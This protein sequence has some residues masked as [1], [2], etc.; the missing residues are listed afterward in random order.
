MSYISVY[1]GVY[2]DLV[3]TLY[4]FYGVDNHKDF[5]KQEIN[6]HIFVDL[7]QIFGVSLSIFTFSS[8]P[9]GKQEDRLER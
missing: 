8:N 3:Y 7:L 4:G 2:G 1:G 6:S 9:L 5:A